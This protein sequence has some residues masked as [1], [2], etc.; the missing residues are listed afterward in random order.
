MIQVLTW[1]LLSGIS[2][3]GS[4]ETSIKKEVIIER[5]FIDVCK[6][7]GIEEDKCNVIKQAGKLYWIDP[8]YILAIWLSENILWRSSH[9][10]WW[11]SK[12]W[13]QMNSCAR[14]KYSNWRLIN[15]NIV[16]QFSDCSLNFTCSTVRT[17]ERIK[18]YY[19]KNSIWVNWN[20][21]NPSCNAKHQWHRP[22]NRYKNKLL[23][24]LYKIE[25]LY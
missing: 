1:I 3:N 20:I 21:S 10:D 22:A 13:Y 9:W 2:L 15:W 12:W 11:C 8:K 16:K 24:N 7:I 6:K 19:C 14:R 25:T 4:I 17:A 5:K 23:K 18:N